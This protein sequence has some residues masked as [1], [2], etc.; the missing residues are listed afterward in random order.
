MGRIRTRV[1]NAG[2]GHVMIAATHTHHGPV[3]ELENAPYMPPIERAIGDC[4]EEAAGKLQP[5]RI[6]LGRTEVDVAHNRRLISEDGRCRMLWRNEE[7]RPTSPVDREMGIVRIDRLDGQPLAILVN[8]ACHPVVMGPSNLEYSADYCGEMARIVKEQTGAECLFLQ[9]GAGNINPYLDKTPIDEGG[10]AS[11]R[12]VGRTCAEAV[13]K[14]VGGIETEVPEA[15]S[16]QCRQKTVVVGTRFDLENDDQRAVLDK[17]YGDTLGVYLKD[18][19]AD[20]AVPLAVLVLNDDLAFAF[21]PGE[22][23]VQYQL[24]L[25]QSSPLRNTF[26]CGYANGFYAYF[27][28]IRDAAAGGYGGLMA[29]YVGVGA[30]DKLAMEAAMEIGTMTNRLKQFYDLKDFVVLEAE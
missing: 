8:F 5:V 25:K 19:T 12:A 18:V 4:I 11:M 14:A 26:L 16:V 7:R 9:G 29:T 6:G 20:L 23:F 13:L 15:P 10:V 30:G 24:E 27:P 28:T 2:I 21:M 17:I 3:M 1:R 22:I